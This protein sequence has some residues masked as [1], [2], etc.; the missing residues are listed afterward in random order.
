LNQIH[1]RR[2]IAKYGWESFTVTIIM[3]G[4]QTREGLN[5]AECAFIAMLD[6]KNNGLNCTDGGEGTTGVVRTDEWKEKQRAAQVGK[7][8]APHT[9]ATKA[10]LSA[11]KM[12]EKNPMF[13]KPQSP[14]TKAKKRAKMLGRKFPDNGPKIS[15]T[16]KGVPFTKEHRAALVVGRAKSRAPRL[17]RVVELRESGWTWQRIAQ[18]VGVGYH[19]ASRWYK[20]YVA[21]AEGYQLR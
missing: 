7:K 17:R 11:Q 3:Q 12:G 19:T 4:I 1:L 8:H 9:E 18:E 15:A 16:K 21:G 6:T 2:A 20:L 5:A 10:I 13:G 14:E